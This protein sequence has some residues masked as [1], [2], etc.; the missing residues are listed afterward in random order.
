M[1]KYWKH[2]DS[3]TGAI[4][5]TPI[6]PVTGQPVDE[7]LF[8]PAGVTLL[9]EAEYKAATEVSAPVVVAPVV[10]QP[11][12]TTQTTT[13]TSSNTTVGALSDVVFTKMNG[14]TTKPGSVTK[15]GGTVTGWDASAWSEVQ[16]VTDGVLSWYVNNDQAAFMLGWSAPANMGSLNWKGMAHTLY[17][18]PSAVG[19]PELRVYEL[20]VEKYRGAFT[21]GNTVILS[22]VGATVIYSI[23]SKLIYTSQ[24]AQGALLV[25]AVIRSQNLEIANIKQFVK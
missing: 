12:T 8:I 21:K 10:E 23:D 25:G 17:F 24:R 6:D 1:A 11:T 4:M 7:N 20:G 2:K 15:T 13:T 14:A 22:L 16:A 9:T 5:A 18:A 3:S 19:T